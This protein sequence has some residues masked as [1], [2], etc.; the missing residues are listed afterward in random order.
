[1]IDAL[2]S[3][4]ARCDRL[5]RPVIVGPPQNTTTIEVSVAQFLLIHGAWHGAWC[6]REV[7]PLLEELGHT[8]RAIDLPGLGDDSTPLHEVTLEKYVTKIVAAVSELGHDVWLVG[9][10]L[11]GVAITQAAELAPDNLSGLV[12]VTAFMPQNGES[13]RDLNANEHSSSLRRVLKFDPQTGF[14][15]VP[16]DHQRDVFYHLCTDEQVAFAQSKLAVEQSMAPGATPLSLSLQRHGRT[17]RFYVEC[18]EDRALSL[19]MQRFMHQRAGVAGIATLQADHSPFFSDPNGLAH[20]LHSFTLA[21][22]RNGQ[23]HSAS[24]LEGPPLSQGG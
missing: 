9:H 8:S 15:A 4:Y 3:E 22:A 18:T 16:T 21:P 7:Q 17:P 5:G 12:Y 19:E 2:D 24:S 14:A 20:A 23:G 6:W 1:M 10:S 11:G 13:L